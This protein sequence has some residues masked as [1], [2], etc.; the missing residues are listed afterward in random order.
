MAAGDTC[1]RLTGEHDRLSRRHGL[2]HLVL[3][4]AG[5]AHRRYAHIK[6]SHLCG[7][8]LDAADDLYTRYGR[9]LANPPHG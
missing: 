3:Q 1:G 9:K 7:H 6:P 2:Q 5:N 4:P 8:I